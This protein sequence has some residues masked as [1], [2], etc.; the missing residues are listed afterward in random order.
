M[1]K[2]KVQN[3]IFS[4]LASGLVGAFAYVWNLHGQFAE[5][6]I[7]LKQVRIEVDQLWV[8]YNYELKEKEIMIS[9]FAKL[10]QR[11]DDMKEAAD[12][13]HDNSVLK[14]LFEQK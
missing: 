3:L 11:V 7:K 12:S 8:N 5:E 10:Q 1:N 14:K 2:D 4:L 13:E 6:T 9:S